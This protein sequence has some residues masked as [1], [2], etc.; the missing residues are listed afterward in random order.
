MKQMLP[1]RF[2][3][4]HFFS[5]IKEASVD[6]V[7]ESLKNEYGSE[8]YFKRDLIVE[9]LISMK[10]NGLLDDT[11]VEFNKNHELCIYYTINAEGSNLLK[12]YLPKSWRAQ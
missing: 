5:Q 9:D 7:M 8:K 6:E 2:R 1:M 10:E 4:L 3:V 11:K 12:K